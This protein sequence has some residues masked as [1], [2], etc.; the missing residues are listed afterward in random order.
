MFQTIIQ[1]I[2]F[3]TFKKSVEYLPVSFDRSVVFG[4][5]YEWF[6]LFYLTDS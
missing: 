3:V 6:I 5:G 4:G 1:R 2:T